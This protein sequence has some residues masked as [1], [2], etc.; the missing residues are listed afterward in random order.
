M[1]KQSIDFSKTVIY[2]IQHIEKPELL[3]VGST[4]NFTQRKN[5]HKSS[6][7]NDNSHKY[8]YKLYQ[9][10]RDNGGWDAFN[11]VIL[12]PFP[13]QNF[14]EARTEEDKVMREMMSSL[15]MK[16]A[17]QTSKE[18]VEYLHKNYL[19]NKDRR[20]ELGKK[21]KLDNK[22]KIKKRSQEYYLETIDKRKESN[23]K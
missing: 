8:N 2:K 19:E 20:N 13:C 18:R 12:K 7:Y 21:W 22:D 15:N 14:N 16:R 10:I 11:M 4:T 3:Y 23:K 17:Y 9:T 6:C 1:P 5:K